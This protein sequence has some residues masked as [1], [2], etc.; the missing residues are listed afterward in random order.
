MTQIFVGMNGD[1]AREQV[2][3]SNLTQKEKQLHQMFVDHFAGARFFANTPE[4]IH[5]P[6]PVQL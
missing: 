6:T 1:E 2:E 5:V 3:H 4:F